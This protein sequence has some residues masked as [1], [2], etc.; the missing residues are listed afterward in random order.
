MSYSSLIYGIDVILFL[1]CLNTKHNENTI[2]QVQLQLKIIH[3]K[4]QVSKKK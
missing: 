1:R 2:N 3:I 4:Q